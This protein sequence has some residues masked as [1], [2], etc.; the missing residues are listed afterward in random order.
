[1]PVSDHRV[2]LTDTDLSLIVS[3]LRAR[4]AMCTGMRRHQVERLAE[5]LGDVAP[6]NPTWRLEAARQT[7]EQFG[8]PK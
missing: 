2:R 6:G 8:A 7:R 4:A 1:V 5:R 3:A